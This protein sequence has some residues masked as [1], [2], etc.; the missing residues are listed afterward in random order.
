MGQLHSGRRCSTISAP[1]I[2]EECSIDGQLYSWPFLLDI[3]GMGWHSG[4]TEAAG[5]SSAPTTWDEYLAAAAA[6][7]ESEGGALRLA[8]LMR[9]AWRSLAPFTHSMSTDVYTEEGAL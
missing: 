1:A 5:I 3:T 8:P 4:L 2:R 9:T 7:V 6:V